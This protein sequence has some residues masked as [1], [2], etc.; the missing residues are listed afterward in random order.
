MPGSG[1]SGRPDAAMW[2]AGGERHAKGRVSK[3]TLGHRAPH[4][5][6]HSPPHS[7][8]TRLWQGAHEPVSR[9]EA[10]KA[11]QADARNRLQRATGP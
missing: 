2:H 3:E 5:P 7:P 1:D 4:N 6:P 9:I 8:P 10:A 11:K